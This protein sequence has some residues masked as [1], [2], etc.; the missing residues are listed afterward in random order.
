MPWWLG[1]LL[2]SPLRRLRQDPAH[3]LAPYVREGMTVLEPGPGMGY[4]TL[5]LAR[6]VGPAGRVVAV[7][8][9]PRM[10]AALRRRAERAGLGARIEVRRATGSDLGVADLAGRV[11]FV[12]AF[13]LV[14]EVPDAGA[15]FAQAAAALEPGGRLLLAEPTGHVSGEEFAETLAAAAARGL[16]PAGAPAIRG[17]RTALLVKR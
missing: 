14:H 12:L 13:A 2:L 17:S 16:A 5:E 1:Y 11:G 8:L 6:R 10:L 4:F 15:F 9:Q 7:D 3:I